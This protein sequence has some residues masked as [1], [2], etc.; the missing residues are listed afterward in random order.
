MIAAAGSIGTGIGGWCM[1]R[2]VPCGAGSASTEASHSY[3]E[4]LISPW[5]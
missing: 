3:W 2:N 5:W 1:A 4:S